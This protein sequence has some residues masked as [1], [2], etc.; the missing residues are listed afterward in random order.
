MKV[1]PS[2]A[3]ELKTV[4]MDGAAGCKVRWLVG[5]SDGAPNFAMRQFEVEPGG[6]TPR[7]H[8][9]YEHE[10]YVL[11]GEGVVFEG[12]QMYPLRPGDVVL[13]KPDEVHQFRNTGA[14]TMKFLCLI[15]N[16]AASQPVTVVPECGSEVDVK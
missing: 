15:P 6:H 14:Q 7:H 16:S 1:T 3:V 5:T 13:V 4:E 2:T 11:E 8:H 9:P 12:E 10:V